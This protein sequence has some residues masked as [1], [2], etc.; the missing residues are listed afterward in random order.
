MKT[1]IELPISLVKTNKN[2]LNVVKSLILIVVSVGLIVYAASPAIENGTLLYY[3]VTLS[4]L[5][6]I[7]FALM[8]LFSINQQIYVPTKSKIRSKVVE[9]TPENY[10]KVLNILSSG[11][12][13]KLNKSVEEGQGMTLD[14]V[15]TKDGNFAAYQFFKY[16]PHNFEPYSEIV[17]VEKDKLSQFCSMFDSRG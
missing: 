1:K 10:S 9:F 5:A 13:S 7:C 14:I 16:I 8:S 15:Y 3:I 17:Y 12:I 2:K 4:S 6:V 11:E